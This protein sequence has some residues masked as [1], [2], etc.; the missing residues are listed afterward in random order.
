M[1]QI[2]KPEELE[3]WQLRN[4]TVEVEGHPGTAYRALKEVYERISGNEF[5]GEFIDSQVAASFD[6]ERRTSRLMTLFTAV[7]ILISLLG[8]LAMST[9]FIRLRAK[10]IAIRKVFGSTNPEVLRRLVKTFL[11]YVLVAFVVATPVTWLLMQRWLSGYSYRISLSPWIF[12]AAGLFCLLVS[13]VTVF[14]Q[15]YAAANAN[16]VNNIKSE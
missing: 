12:V 8:L 10:E 3:W 7:A 1:V 6:A 9:Y 15:S 14:F 16:P 11:S 5:S 4:L 13:F 2:R